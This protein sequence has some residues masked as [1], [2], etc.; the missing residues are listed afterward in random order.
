LVQARPG[1]PGQFDV[2]VDGKVVATRRRSLLSLL[3]GGWPSAD[4]VLRA[5]DERAAP[6]GG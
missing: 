1:G 3:G 2:V 5:I 4:E 6:A